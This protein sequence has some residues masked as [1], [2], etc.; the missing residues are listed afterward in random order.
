MHCSRQ[1]QIMRPL[2]AWPARSTRALLVIRMHGSQLAAAAS[3]GIPDEQ[4][5]VEYAWWLAS[6]IADV[7][8][9]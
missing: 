8:V 7:T 4:R 6:N 1:Q 2:P 9:I 5:G 3:D